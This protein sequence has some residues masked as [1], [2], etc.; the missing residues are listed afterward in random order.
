MEFVK[1][2]YEKIVLSAV[3][4]GLAAVVVFML[5][6][7]DSEKN[8]LEEKR[9]GITARENQ[10]RPLH[11]AV[12]DAALARSKKT[13]PI[14]LSGGHNTFNPVMWQ[15][16][17]DGTRLKVVTGKEVGPEAAVVTSI[18]PLYTILSLESISGNSYKIGI[19][20]QAA[21]NKY[22]RNKQVRYASMN[23]P[24]SEFFL[25]KEVKGAPE[26]PDELVVELADTKELA[27]FS[28]DNP[29]QRIDDYTAEIK[30]DLEGRTFSNLRTGD[31]ISFAGDDYVVEIN[32]EEVI[33]SSQSSTK[34]TVLKLTK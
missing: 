4:V 11:T 18:T 13:L 27:N 1:K 22:E 34:K 33:L 5:M 24:K 29:F 26:K 28:K 8:Y 16:K 10:Y 19:T 9:K 6:R 2:H 14:I 17:L 20:R 30:Y 31:K 7:I 23:S 32:P 25:L 12:Y 15:V 3:L 21:K